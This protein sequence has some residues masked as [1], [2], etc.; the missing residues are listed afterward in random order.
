[1]ALGCFALCANAQEL[2]QTFSFS[3]NNFFHGFIP[4]FLTSDHSAQFWL[5]TNYD[6]YNGHKKTWKDV[7]IFDENMKQIIRIAPPAGIIPI[8]YISSNNDGYG[9]CVPTTQKIFDDDKE[10]EYITAIPEGGIAIMQDDGTVL[11]TLNFSSGERMNSIYP[12]DNDFPIEVLQFNDKYYLLLKLWKEDENGS[13]G[14]L[15]IIRMYSF[16][17]GK[18]STSIKK[19]KDIPNRMKV[20]PTLP[21]KNESI[22]MDLVDMKS[23]KRLSVIDTNGKVCLTQSIQPNQTNVEL[24]TSGMPA[25]MYIIRVTD[26]NRE[27]DN[28]R[29]II[30]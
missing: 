11:A 30:R 27:V 3:G 16:D 4:E 13:A 15:D 7:S 23:P 21:Q 8:K 1:M 18:I 14:E 25:G 26:G 19:V 9:Y 12:A 22:K 6:E 20:T 24:S 2:E 29:V 10:Y 28:C 17:M 5:S